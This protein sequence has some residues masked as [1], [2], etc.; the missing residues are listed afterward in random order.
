MPPAA[1]P[2]G[3]CQYQA[4]GVLERSTRQ[5]HQIKRSVH[6]TQGSLTWDLIAIS[7][8]MGIKEKKGKHHINVV[9]KQF[10][11]LSTQLVTHMV[12]ETN[13][14]SVQK[15]S[16]HPSP[17]D[18]CCVK[19]PQLLALCMGLKMPARDMETSKTAWS[20]RTE[21]EWRWHQSNVVWQCVGMATCYGACVLL[22]QAMME[23]R[24][25]PTFMELDAQRTTRLS[26]TSNHKVYQIKKTDLTTTI[27]YL[28]GTVWWACFN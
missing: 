6:N 2:P 7:V 5:F 1:Y 13:R 28:S 4:A 18:H 22:P 20:T 14:S 19:E 26:S 27:Y 3:P 15:H 11:L 25:E 10:L 23:C 16:R 17:I 9:F 24:R 8:D 12:K 21:Q